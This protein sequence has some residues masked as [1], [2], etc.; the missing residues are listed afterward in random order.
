[1]RVTKVAKAESPH[2]ADDFAW[3]I[4]ERVHLPASNICRRAQRGIQIANAYLYRLHLDSPIRSIPMLLLVPISLFGKIPLF[5]LALSLSVQ[6]LTWYLLLNKPR[7]TSLTS[8]ILPRWLLPRSESRSSHL[9]SHC[10][11][12]YTVLAEQKFFSSSWSWK[13]FMKGLALTF[14]SSLSVMQSVYSCLPDAKAGCSRTVEA[15]SDLPITFV[16]TATI[17]YVQGYAIRRS[18]RYSTCALNC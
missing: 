6:R 18:T 4:P 5:A 1:M 17:R 2:R 12:E 13:G 7:W 8:Q 3:I 14:C 16:G 11:I 15:T 10:S 9:R